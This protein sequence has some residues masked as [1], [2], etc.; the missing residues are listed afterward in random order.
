[1]TSRISLSRD[2]GT[3]GIPLVRLE[4]AKWH[5]SMTVADAK[6]FA[7]TLLD[8]VGVVE[9]DEIFKEWASTAGDSDPQ[10]ARTLL[11][12]F[13]RYRDGRKTAK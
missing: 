12:D 7:H 1:M 8:F 5:E 3:S 2:F 10:R 11:A 6:R 9:F 4:G 13:Q